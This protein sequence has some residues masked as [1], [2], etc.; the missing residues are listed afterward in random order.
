MENINLTFKVC[1]LHN[2]K[3]LDVFLKEKVLKFSRMQIKKLILCNKVQIN[4]KIINIPK[5]KFF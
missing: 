5:K 4:Y 3:R 1:L 2:K